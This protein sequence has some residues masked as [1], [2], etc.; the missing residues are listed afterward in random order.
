MTREQAAAF[1]FSQSVCALAEI[2]AMKRTK[3]EHQ[4]SFPG[5]EKPYPPYSANHFREVAERF[6]IGENVVLQLFQDVNR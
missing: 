3:D 5:P 1:V 2:E 6:N 4:M